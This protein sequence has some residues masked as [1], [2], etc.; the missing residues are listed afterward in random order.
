MLLDFLA[1]ATILDVAEHTAAKRIGG[2]RKERIPTGLALRVFRDGSV[3]PSLE[4]VQKF[5]LEYPNA[6]VT[7]EALPATE[8]EEIKYKNNF[9]VT[10]NP[11]VGFDVID[12]EKA[13]FLS[14]GKRI[15]IISPV[16]KT[17]PK[18][19]LF[20][21]T[22]YNEDGTPKST[23][24]D[25][26]AKTFGEDSLW[27]MLTEVYGIEPITKEAEID[28]IDLVFVANPNN[29]EPWSLPNGNQV[30]YIP[31]QIRRGKDAGS[32]NTVRRELPIFY[33][34]LPASYLAPTPAPVAQSTDA[35]LVTVS[36][37]TTA[38][39]AEVAEAVAQ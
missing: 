36:A 39:T 31:K 5:N 32:F 35:E 29:N 16:A 10:G 38:V 25:Q 19:D 30:A 1:S 15:L 11:G 3:Y 33:A 18:V 13:P 6:S 37:E 23:V 28:Y 8:G 24:I 21:S 9:A 7:K 17:Q 2:A 14:F 27:P 12:T 20:G 4:L 34:L 26:G 22:V